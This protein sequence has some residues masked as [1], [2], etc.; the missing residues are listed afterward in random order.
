M[1]LLCEHTRLRQLRLDHESFLNIVSCIGANVP[2]VRFLSRDDGHV[3]SAAHVLQSERTSAMA[4]LLRNVL[5]TCDR[6]V[7][8]ANAQQRLRV[9]DVHRHSRIYC[10]HLHRAKNVEDGR[11]AFYMD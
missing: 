7:S 11:K 3:D 8:F 5:N 9:N 10:H 6:P 1:L 2:G 4:S